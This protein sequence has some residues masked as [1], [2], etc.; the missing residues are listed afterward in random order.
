MFGHKSKPSRVWK[1]AV[2]VPPREQPHIFDE[3][4][5]ANRYR[6]KLV[7]LEIV[8]RKRVHD[9]LQQIDPPLAELVEREQSKEGEIEELP[10][11]DKDARKVAK[12]ELRVVRNQIKERKALLYERPDFLEGQKDIEERFTQEKKDARANCGLYW[13]T[14]CLVE[15]ERVNDRKG[16]PPRFRKFDGGKIG[17]QIQK[18]AMEAHPA[19]VFDSE[20]KIAGHIFVDE[21]RFGNQDEEKN[22]GKHKVRV[23]M[24]SGTTGERGGHIH[25]VFYA[26]LHRDM[27]DLPRNARIKWAWLQCDRVGVE[28][29]WSLQITIAA[30]SW[31]RPDRI[32]TSGSVGV[33]VGWRVMKDGSLRVA[34]WIDDQGKRGCVSIP[35]ER[36]D[37]YLHRRKLQSIRDD[38]F[39]EVMKKLIAWRDDHTDILPEW[40]KERAEHLAKWKAKGKLASLI[41]YWRDH[42]FAG[43]EEIFPQLDGGPDSHRWEN[44]PWR[45]KDKHLATW[46]AHEHRGYQCWRKDVYRK[47][48]R[49]L[50]QTYRTCYYEDCDWSQIARRPDTWE[51]VSKIDHETMQ[52]Y[53]AAA[54]VSYLLEEIRQMFGD[55]AQQV[56]ARHTTMQCHACG[57]I[58]DWD[59]KI[60]VHECEHCGKAWDQ[61]ANA[62]VNILGRGL[63]S[64][65]G[66]AAMGAHSP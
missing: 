28:W 13:G 21:A 6:N 18:S 10:P 61:D 58:C 46:E 30:D 26:R 27:R 20:H 3:L 1:F 29:V 23:R 15:R 38:L 41:L 16:Y 9:F 50:A 54:A 36:V 22:C 31:E 7:E 65:A 48:V 35:R 55:H 51:D 53:R 34:E 45:N 60:L 19:D 2:K 33:D 39:N 43:D 24:I 49:K 63:A 17:I 42:R 4:R 14:Y 47:H 32:T 62:A 56:D 25:S 37:Q 64:D 59:H 5:R 12:K 66:S 8:R 57:G 40:W 44:P 52:R 11:E